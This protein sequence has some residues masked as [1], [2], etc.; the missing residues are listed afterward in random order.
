MNGT[1]APARVGIFYHSDPAG[2]VPSG[3]D[4]FIRGILQFAPP[5]LEY[6]LYGASSD[7]LARPPGQFC[8]FSLG[9]RA[10]R[11]MPLIAVSPKADKPLTPDTVLF[12]R[13]LRL[14]RNSG[15]LADLDVLDFHRI[16]PLWLFR[17]DRRCRNLVLHQDMS[18]L[19]EPG[20]DIKW[21][22]APWL[23]E[24]IE[25]RAFAL[26]QSVSIVRASAVT[27]YEAMYPALKGLFHFLPTW[28]DPSTFG[29]GAGPETR[30]QLR[31]RLQAR[32]RVAPET[33]VLAFVG[34]F[35][36]QKDPLLLLSALRYLYEHGHRM[37]LVLV[38]DGVMRRQLASAIAGH[39]L[40]SS[41]TMTGPLPRHEIAAVL[42][43]AD[44]FVLSSE[45]EGMPIAVLEALACGLP[46]ASTDVGEIG[47]AVR[48]GENGQLARARTPEAL[49]QAI[50]ALPDGRDPAVNQRCLQSV[51]QFRPETVLSVLYDRHREQARRG[52]EVT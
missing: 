20:C 11:F 40:V 21:R 19:R 25:A 28:Y 34:R 15:A 33:R 4:S 22:Y 14:L 39:R 43:G 23:Y 18:I 10:V 17:R 32:C 29:L 1:G 8:D 41:V 26:V 24:F 42:G 49:A 44:A 46:V 36:R 30:L 38:G 9:G 2:F 50:L 52:P 13:R 48:N 51:A 35:D 7:P 5:D 27:R 3:V 37:H 6:T 47:R 45:Y 12:M 16:E 31:A